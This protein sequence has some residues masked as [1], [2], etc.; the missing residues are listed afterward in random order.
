MLARL[1]YVAAETLTIAVR[2]TQSCGGNRTQHRSESEG[3]MTINRITTGLSERDETAL[4]TE[5][6]VRFSRGERQAAAYHPQYARLWSLA[7]RHALGGKLIRPAL[8]LNAYRALRGTDRDS[9][10]LPQAV[11]TVAAAIELLH[12]SFLLHDDVIDGD[13]TRRG[14]PNLIGTLAAEHDAADGQSL[15]WARSCGIL[16]G[17]L[18]LADVHQMFARID[19]PPEIRA[20]L[21]ELLAH[22][23]TES[24]AGEQLDVGF[25]DRAIAAESATILDMSRLKT[26]T[27]TFELPLRAAAILAGLDCRIGSTL[28]LAGAYLGLAFQLQ[29][30]LLST[31]GDASL[32]GKDAFSDIR[33]GKETLLI[34]HARMTSAWPSIEPYFG[35]PMLTQSQGEMIRDQLRECGAERY[36]MGLVDEQVR[37]L[38]ELLAAHTS[39]LTGPVCGVILSLSDALERRSV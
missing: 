30:D 8:A 33:E 25:T 20:D 19:E 35:S 24:V 32:H 16:M 39:D 14:T 26:A 11:V 5:L 21:L 31:F 10:D 28:A 7:S 1:V 15:H 23:I 9:S 22:T 2:H 34:A 29:D 36:V 12:Y 13:L 17:N 18:L 4:R 6:S 38:H 37:A 3:L 27:Y